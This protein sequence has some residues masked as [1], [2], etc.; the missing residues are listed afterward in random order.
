MQDTFHFHRLNTSM[1]NR[2]KKRIA[3]L[4]FHVIDVINDHNSR[5]N[6]LPLL[7]KCYHYINHILTKYCCTKR[8]EHLKQQ[9]QPPP[10]PEQQNKINK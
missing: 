5:S 1:P 2:K 4:L 10:P 6:Y 3:E 8:K 9:Q 7:V